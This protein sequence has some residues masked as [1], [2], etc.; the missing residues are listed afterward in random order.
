MACPT[1][2]PGGS[3]RLC[4]VQTGGVTP[5]GL[6]GASVPLLKKPSPPRH[7]GRFPGRCRPTD[8]SKH[9]H[10]HC[11]TRPLG[12]RAACCPLGPPQHLVLHL[13][14]RHLVM[15]QCPPLSNQAWPPSKTSLLSQMFKTNIC[16]PVFPLKRTPSSQSNIGTTTPRHVSHAGPQC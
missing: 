4:S 1:G 6:R 16:S 12:P 3:P 5:R 7:T 15:L 10:P 11:P 2:G 13:P 14:Q 8:E 9:P